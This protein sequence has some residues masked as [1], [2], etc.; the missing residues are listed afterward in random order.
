MKKA[1]KN[2][3]K[4]IWTK[5][6]EAFV[7][8][9]YTTMSDVE[10]A[11]VL[12]MSKSAVCNYRRSKK[13]FAT[14]EQ[15]IAKRRAGILKNYQ[16]KEHPHDD[17]IRKNYLTMPVKTMGTK[18]NKSNV[19]IERRFKE[20]GLVIPPHII[21]ARKKASQKKPGDVPMNKGMK[22]TDYMTPEAIARTAK[23]RFKKGNLPKNTLHDGKV[24]IRKDSKGNKYKWIRLSLGKWKMLHVKI[25]EDEHGPLPEGTIVVFKDGNSMNCVLENLEH[26]TKAEHMMANTIQRYPEDLRKVMILKGKLNKKIKKITYEQR[27][28]Q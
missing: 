19:Y 15:V 16:D 2:G 5:K 27:K 9:N 26:R 17:F 24:T 7:N 12:G 8:A 6:H 23:T 10:L 28:E 22:Q 14:K 18:I 20:L 21:E 11:D 25:W 4:F 13:L 3:N 1:K